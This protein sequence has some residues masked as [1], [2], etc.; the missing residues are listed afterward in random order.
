MKE[1]F[2]TRRYR[3]L[4]LQSMMIHIKSLAALFVLCFNDEVYG[5]W[6]TTEHLSDED[7]SAGPL[8]MRLE[9]DWILTY[10]NRG[11][12]FFDSGTQ[13]EY[14]LHK[15]PMMHELDD[16]VFTYILA[17]VEEEDSGVTTVSVLETPSIQGEVSLVSM[18]FQ[19]I[20]R[21]ILAFVFEDGRSGSIRM[22]SSTYTFVVSYDD[23]TN[24]K[25]Q[26]HY[27]DREALGN[28]LFDCY[29]DGEENNVAMI[30]QYGQS[31]TFSG[32]K[33]LALAMF[34]LIQ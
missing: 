9:D 31:Y 13:F 6:P 11:S 29:E 18:K 19:P 22:E 4:K 25:C 24:V 2:Q 33:Y 20:S 34:H 28:L 17:V 14:E 8:P 1:I 3:N 30:R 23:Q 32:D 27:I 15:S 26:A 10:K 21:N 7:L 5:S 12:R 16:E